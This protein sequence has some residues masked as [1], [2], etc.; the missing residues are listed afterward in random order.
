MNLLQAIQNI[1]TTTNQGYNENPTEFAEV[2]RQ[3]RELYPTETEKAGITA[4]PAEQLLLAIHPHPAVK[5]ALSLNTQPKSSTVWVKLLDSPHISIKY[6]TIANQTLPENI[7]TAHLNRLNPTAIEEDREDF[8]LAIE[9]QTQRIKN[10]L[11]PEPTVVER[12][13]TLISDYNPN[14]LGTDTQ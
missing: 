5:Y 7:L 9:R 2:I 11:Q 12:I 8:M 3:G 13:K 10:G 1:F 6:N 14:T 4:D